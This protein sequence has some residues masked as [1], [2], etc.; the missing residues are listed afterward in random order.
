VLAGIGG[1]LLSGSFLERRLSAVLGS[2]DDRRASRFAGD[3]ARWWRAVRETCGPATSVRALADV[4]LRPLSTL[5]G[6]TVSRVSRVDDELWL[7]ALHAPDLHLPAV[8]CVWGAPLDRTWRTSVRLGLA[9]G[10]RWC[11]LFNGTH[12][13]I[14]DGGAASARRHL[15]FEF[16]ALA[17]HEPSA[18]IAWLLLRHAC[19]E[20]DR[21]GS[22]LAR[23]VATADQ[24]GV[25]V[26][27]GLRRGVRDALEHLASGILEALPAGPR[28]TRQAGGAC[29]EGLTAVYRMLFLLFAEARGLV[30]SWHPVYGASYTMEALRAAAEPPG[31]ARGLWE[32]F[33]AMSRLAHQG[34]HADD[35]RVTAFN[36][37]LFAPRRSPLLD[38]R[39]VADEALAEAVRALS[40][41][42]TPR[43]RERVAYRDLGVEQ[44]GAVYETL[45][46]YEPGVR[47]D[48]GRRSVVLER[49]GPAR[50][51]TSGTF[52]TPAPITRALVR[53]ALEPLTLRASP[54][55]VLAL[56]VVDP[57]MGSGAFL[58]AACRYL[59]DAY[60]AALV[61]DGRC[62]SGDISDGDRAGFRRLVAQRCLFGADANPM[63]VHLARLSLWLTTLAA[64][65]PLGFLDHHLVSGDSLLGVTA[66]HVAQRPP[67]PATARRDD[68][69][70][71]LFDL[72]RLHDSTRGALAIRRRLE[73]DDE[74]TAAD[75]QRK[76]K[77]LDT[78]MADGAIGRWRAVCDL[79]CAAFLGDGGLPVTLFPALVEH[80]LG[81][82]G[83]L[84]PAV[85]E[86]ALV[87]LRRAAA[88]RR[89]LHWPFEF[90]E[91]F[92]DESGRE[93]PGG[94]FDAVVGNPPWE[95]VRADAGR[96]GGSDAAAVRFTRR[97]GLYH[98]QSDG[99]LNLY[100]AFVERAVHLARP[101][102]RI[103]LVL[104]HGFASD[105]GAGRLRHL[106]LRHCATDRIIGFENR[107]GVFPIHRSMR[108]LLV[109]ATTGGET[110]RVACRFGLQDPAVLDGIA[111]AEASDPAAAFPV[112]LTPA[113][114]E[115]LSGPD[116]AIPDLRTPTDLQI[117]E[118]LA[119][120]H[121]RLTSPSGWGLHFGRELNATADR[122]HFSAAPGGLPVVDGKH[123]G[124]FTVRI[125]AV[126]HR[127]RVDVARRLLPR[128][129]YLRERLA[130]RDVTAATN[131]TTL[132]AALVPAGC[133]TTHSLFCLRTPLPRAEQLL[134]CAVFNS[135]V[136]NYLVRMRVS[137]HVTLAI[138][139][140]LPV[141]RL[142]ARA[143]I[144][145]AIVT[146]ARELVAGGE[147][148]GPVEADLQA[149]AAEAYGLTSAEL[150]HV[151]GTFP[152]VP[153]AHRTAV[154]GEFTRATRR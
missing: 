31:Q 103:A 5:L 91:V 34:C 58:V 127:I 12:L 137:S 33:Q 69:Q 15:D 21:G 65:R 90:P 83:A 100:Q 44:L 121:P 119:V 111:E 109:T 94:G 84:P 52:Y 42:A 47:D 132:I 123:L 134:L 75:V 38:T 87:P 6:V 10:S 144:G 53:Q 30:P 108:F 149:L 56:R 93:H 148:G 113:V 27:A 26:C 61:R 89:F 67:S 80:L 101:G 115:R 139:D 130:F 151:L 40:T 147:R 37:R 88:D 122:E 35:L 11:A 50:R 68:R 24:D 153:E 124:P 112:Q 118:R 48:D 64:D 13:R 16:E 141:P 23:I 9:T 29:E 2:H 49:T 95:M 57:A 63:A 41:A 105:L 1:D 8:L 51:K 59:A 20:P 131:R 117:A 60:E 110:D 145:A 28:G 77:A 138:L 136:A 32:A 3:L 116:L 7:S 74:A 66:T 18:R 72:E 76:E 133:V 79:W 55:A 96:L 71:S 150:E 86:A 78:L 36:G 128:Q 114:L 81:G 98:A 135:F 104:P 99:H 92:C 25:E 143:G 46:E 43:G 82:P 125:D 140:T 62:L 70:L 126:K 102:G 106:L 154:L 45:L 39:P 14:A 22:V 146:L 107:S 19:F 129:P 85:A 97:S 152:L 142:D 4:A 120:A 54:E 17:E 73:R